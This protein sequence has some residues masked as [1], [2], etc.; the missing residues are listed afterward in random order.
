[1]FLGLRTLTYHVPDLEAAKTWYREVLGFGPYFDQP[2]YVGFEVGGYELGLVPEEGEV[3][4]GSSPT[5][6]W[7]VDDIE[8]AH[9]RLVKLGAEPLGPIAEVGG[10]ILTTEVKDPWGNVFGII[11]NPHFKLN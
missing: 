9:A 5:C 1:M 6:Y 2:F 3:N 10:G 7:G 4:R 11:F 8:A